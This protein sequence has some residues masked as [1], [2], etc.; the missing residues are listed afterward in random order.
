V[1]VSLRLPLLRRS[2]TATVVIAAQA[3]QVTIRVAETTKAVHTFPSTA[4]VSGLT[5]TKPLADLLFFRFNL[6]DF[7]ALV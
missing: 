4:L 6:D 3:A 7:D 5:E 1:E 2:C